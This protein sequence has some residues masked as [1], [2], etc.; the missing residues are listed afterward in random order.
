VAPRLS[1]E[2]P[3]K[4]GQ[5]ASSICQYRFMAIVTTSTVVSKA[6]SIP[7]WIDPINASMNYA[8]E[9]K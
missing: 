3:T 1:R 6:T 5:E 8:L 4:Q 9:K 7:T 2:A